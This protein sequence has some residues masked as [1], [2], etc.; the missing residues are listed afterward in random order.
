[1]PDPH[2]LQTTAWAQFQTA[3]GRETFSA[4]GEDWSWLA[5]V[6]RGRLG[7]RLY[8]PYGPTARDKS[9]LRE[10]VAS[11]RRK[12]IEL[13]LDFVRLEP[14]APVSAEDLKALGAQPSVREIQPEHT[15]QIDLTQPEEIVVDNI[16]SGNRR[17]Y[18][19]ASTKE[20]TFRTS[21][22]PAEIDIFLSCIH[23]VAERTGMQPHSD[24]YFHTQAA[25]LMPLHTEAL[26]VA[27]VAGEPAA[28]ILAIDSPTTRY[29]AHAAA[30]YSFHK[31]QAGASLTCYAI[32]EA[33]RAGKKTFDFYG[34]APP[35]QPNHRWAGFTRFKQSFGGQLVTYLGTWDIPLHRQRYRLYRLAF[36]AEYAKRRLI[37][38]RSN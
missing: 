19:N 31:A 28:T 34:V 37:Q 10:A 8:C 20:L 30:H 32:V 2:F 35:D 24:A 7:S 3:L 33:L 22:D 14:Q 11:L 18:K 6:E 38:S 36:A 23:E 12:A 4:S 5:I 1:M 16:S 13:Q 27:E 15:W 21:Y 25:T 26:L 29:Y 17:N 9:A